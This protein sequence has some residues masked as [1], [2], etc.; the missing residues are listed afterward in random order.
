MKRWIFIAWWIGS[1]GLSLPAQ[2]FYSD[3]AL[4]KGIDHLYRVPGIAGGVSF[5]DFDRD[6]W[7]DITLASEDGQPIAIYRN[8]R[9][10]FQKLPVPIDHRE[11]VK[12]L[13]WVDYDNDGDKDLY[14]AT[15]GGANRLYENTGGLEG[16]RL[17]DITQTAG[18]PLEDHRTYGAAWGDYNRDGWL[19][20]YYGERK[21][22]PGSATNENRL[23]RNNTDG[24]FT[25]VTASTRT[26]DP[27]KI[28][29]CSAFLDYNKDGWPDLYTAND[30]RSGNTLLENQGDPSRTGVTFNDVSFITHSDLKMDAMCVAVGD[31]DNDS[32]P[33][34]YITNLPPGNALLRNTTASTKGF[35]EKAL[36][37]GVGMFGIGWGANFLDADNDGDLDL[38]VSANPLGIDTVTSKLYLNTGNGNFREVA[39]GF[40]GDTVSSYS[41]AVGDF[42]QDGYPDIVV[43]N[44]QD[45]KTQ[46]WQ[47]SGGTHHWLKIELEGVLSNRDAVGSTI[48]LFADDSYQMRYTHCGIGFMAQ[49]STTEIF[50]VGGHELVDSVRITW[51][52]G[53][54]DRL[55]N[56]GV[57]QKLYI[58]E[59][60]TTNGQIYVDP[61]IEIIPVG[62]QNI[63]PEMI[64]LIAYPNPVG[65]V[66]TVELK[67]HSF[68]QYKVIDARGRVVLQGQMQGLKEKIKVNHL[69]SGLYHLTVNDGEGKRAV[70]PWIKL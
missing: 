65:S 28:P 17:K 40:A 12:Q 48:E 24:T 8:D 56:I 16:L 4:F 1:G 59:G 35:E 20:L 9:G 21:V 27:G 5:C 15:Y 42:N 43:Q 13:L 68:S 54:V 70:L 66:L 25:E 38:Y 41:N 67:D 30:K 55:A 22:P 36:A 53:H 50:G 44:D 6:G 33:D 29:F 10:R 18:L 2:V 11:E 64:G 46:L 69:S 3:V 47:N 62:T 61:Q 14:L 37:T 63:A 49:N 39:A 57:D 32:W 58:K 31:Y 60:S 51:P 52:T 45:A 7:D 26:R 19:D 34:I 23:F